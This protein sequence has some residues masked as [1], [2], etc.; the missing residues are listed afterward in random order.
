MACIFPSL[1]DLEAFKD[2]YGDVFTMGQGRD[3]YLSFDDAVAKAQW[4]TE[5]F[6]NKYTMLAVYIPAMDGTLRFHVADVQTK[7][8]TFDI[9]GIFRV[10]YVIITE[11]YQKIGHNF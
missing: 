5:A 3:R 1:E 11:D 9:I 6:Y 4:N 10:K 8:E 7:N 2:N